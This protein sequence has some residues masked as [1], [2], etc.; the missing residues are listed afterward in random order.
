MVDTVNRIEFGP[1]SGRSAK[2]QKKATL[3]KLPSYGGVSFLVVRTWVAVANA[4]QVRP[5]DHR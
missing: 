2:P 3:K 1:A 5:D 4:Q